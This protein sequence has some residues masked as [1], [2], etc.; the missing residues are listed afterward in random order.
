MLHVGKPKV[1]AFRIFCMKSQFYPF[2]NDIFHIFTELCLSRRETAEVL[3][4]TGMLFIIIAVQFQVIGNFI[5]LTKI[6]LFLI[7]SIF[8]ISGCLNEKKRNSVYLT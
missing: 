7:F 6:V 2:R 5:F 4:V 3:A 1:F 8:L